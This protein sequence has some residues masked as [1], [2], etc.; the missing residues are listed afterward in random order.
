MNTT[1]PTGEPTLQHRAPRAD[2]LG[3]AW[4]AVALIPVFFLLSMAVGYA[5]YEL[6]GYPA[7]TG[8][9]PLWAD[10][11]VAVCSTLVFLLPCSAAIVYGRRAQQHGNRGGIAPMAIGACAGIAVIALTV[12][13][14]VGSQL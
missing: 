5:L 3:L 12:V 9:A 1:M 10:L 14:V 7:D 4:L 6:T 8:V 11:V 2:Q 13:T